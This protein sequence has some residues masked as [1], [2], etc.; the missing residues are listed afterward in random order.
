MAL[1]HTD[2]HHNASTHDDSDRDSRN[3][4]HNHDLHD[5]KV[6]AS[7]ESRSLESGI[8]HIEQ[9]VAQRLANPARRG[10]FKGAAASA[11]LGFLGTMAAPAVAATVAQ[12][13]RA[14]LRRPSR[15]GF[16][17]VAKHRNDVLTVPEGYSASVLYRLGDPLAA[18][19]PAYRNDGQDAAASFAH[20]A[21]DHHDAI[22]YFGLGRDGRYSATSSTRGL[23]VMN[24]EAITPMFLHANG[25]ST[26]GSGAAQVR[27]SPEEVLREFY[28]HGV[29]VVEVERNSDGAWRTLQNSRF[30]RRI[31]TL[32]EMALTGPAAGTPYMVTK[33]SPNGTH[34][35]GTINNCAHGTTPWNTYLTCEENYANYFR[36]VAATDDARRSAK[37]LASFKRNGIAGNGRELWAT[38]TPDTPDDLY[39]RWNAEVRGA[40]A[41]DDYRNV[42]NTFGWVVEL[43]PFDPHSMPR[44]RTALGRFAHEG[45]WLGPVRA[46]RPLVWYSGDD[47]RNEY[48]Y[49]YVSNA[50][51]D[52][53]DAR[54]GMAAGDKYLDSGKLYAARFDA[55]GTGEWLELKFGSGAINPRSA[56]YAFADQADVLINARLAAEAAGATKMDRPEWGAVDPVNGQVYMTL[57]NN[58]A[59]LRPLAQ[60]DAANPRHYNDARTNGSAQRGNPN[61]HIIRWQEAR[62]DPAASKFGWDIYLFAARAGSDASNVNLSGL[63]DDNDLSSPDGMWFSNATRIAWI[64]TDDG[65][66][67]DVTNCMMLAALPGQVGDGG[68]AGRKRI[69]NTDANGAVREV[70]TQVGSPPGERLKRFLVGPVQ[71]EITGVTETPD[72]RA[73]FVNIQHPGEDTKAAD[74]ANPAAWPSHWPDGGMARPRSATVVITRNDGG[75]IGL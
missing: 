34:T 43:D 21:G 73:L 19:V 58:T 5:H 2:H 37:E 46:G 4:H 65:A 42:P 11:A 50:N 55:D 13:E 75:V 67:T 60:L 1:D 23:L 15:L 57:T 72:G 49:K 38:P 56:G 69:T 52:P 61:G 16:K 30:N 39:G 44:K 68:T 28:V 41:A 6:D 35:R 20:R 18:N 59:A 14:P 3:P 31:H 64:Q 36:R 47:A 54:G 33:Y 10:L 74:M 27:T 66:F 45:A 48:I 22:Q 17:A 26:Q 8:A 9:V 7:P 63:T 12:T 70:T 53:A 25:V 40:S 29:A 62:N 24:H 51:W 32:T 71:C